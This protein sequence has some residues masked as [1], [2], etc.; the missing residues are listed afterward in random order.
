MKH[1]AFAAVP[2]VAFSLTSLTSAAVA[3]V[4]GRCGWTYIGGTYMDGAGLGTERWTRR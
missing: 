3:Q 4:I 2:A 1:L